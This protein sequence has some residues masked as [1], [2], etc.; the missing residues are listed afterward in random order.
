MY[1]KNIIVATLLITFGGISTLSAQTDCMQKLEDLKRMPNR[2]DT[3]KII[4]PET[5]EETM[6]TVSVYLPGAPE[7]YAKVVE[8]DN[9]KIYYVMS[10]NCLMIRK[11]EKTVARTEEE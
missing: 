8:K 7:N 9:M 6:Q 4:D 1:T 10:D 5:Y 2:V 3:V 11:V